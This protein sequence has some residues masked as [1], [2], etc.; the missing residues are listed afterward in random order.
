MM[1]VAFFFTIIELAWTCV[2]GRKI[3]LEID[4]EFALICVVTVGVKLAPVCTSINMYFNKETVFA[5]E[6]HH[7]V[8]MTTQVFEA[9]T[10][11]VLLVLT[12]LWNTHAE[13]LK[14]WL[15]VYLSLVPFKIMFLWCTHKY[16]LWLSHHHR[17]NEALL[18]GYDS[19]IF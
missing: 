2:V 8:F 10:Y 4:H 18:K 15:I 12:R 16:W 5:R 9:I 1:F 3:Y 13:L 17:L 7:H 6:A 19:V 11:G 14:L